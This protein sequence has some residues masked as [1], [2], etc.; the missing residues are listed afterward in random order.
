MLFI[1]ARLGAGVLA[2]AAGFVGSLG[3]CSYSPHDYSGDGTMYMV[4]KATPRYDVELGTISLAS[5]SVSTYRLEGLPSSTLLALITLNDPN[6]PK[7]K[8]IDDGG[9]RVTATLTELETGRMSTKTGLLG[10]AWKRSA[11]SW[12]GEVQDFEGVWFTPVR[13]SS[14]SLTIEVTVDHPS[15]GVGVV[16][17]TVHV[18]GG[19]FGTY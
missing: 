14:Y 15:T 6:D 17:G 10:S 18:R 5:P 3:G 16:E 11:E 4:P 2:C 12:N 9:V 19:G 1:K 13:H 7:M 8:W